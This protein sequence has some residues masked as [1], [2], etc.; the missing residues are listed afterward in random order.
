MS[1]VLMEKKNNNNMAHFVRK[2]LLDDNNKFAIGKITHTNE[3]VCL[4][5]IA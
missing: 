5:Y 4:Y 2:A 3:A 1:F